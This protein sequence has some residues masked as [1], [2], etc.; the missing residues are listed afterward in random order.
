MDETSCLRLLGQ[1]VSG[2][3]KQTL[4]QWKGQ[5]N[6][7]QTQNIRGT[8]VDPGGRDRTLAVKSRKTPLG[9]QIFFFLQTYSWDRIGWLP[10]TP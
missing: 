2:R 5:E 9:E 6:K 4:P 7:V 8:R 3:S 10:G 1:A